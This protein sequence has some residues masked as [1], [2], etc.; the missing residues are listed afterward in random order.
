[1]P[2]GAYPQVAGGAYPQLEPEWVDEVL[3]KPIG[4]PGLKIS[5]SI[6]TSAQRPRSPLVR[7]A[8]EEPVAA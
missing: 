1:M 6:A 2:G 8:I 7:K 3:L 5:L 4:S